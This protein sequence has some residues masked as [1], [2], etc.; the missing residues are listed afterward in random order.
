MAALRQARAKQAPE[1]TEKLSSDELTTLI[2]AVQDLEYFTDHRQ[3]VTAIVEHIL[4]VCNTPGEARDLLF[5]GTGPAVASYLARILPGA[6]WAGLSRE[7]TDRM[8]LARDMLSN[9]IGFLPVSGEEENLIIRAA[10]DVSFFQ[11][12]RQQVMSAVEHL[13]MVC[14][15]QGGARDELMARAPNIA[16]WLDTIVAAEGNFFGVTEQERVRVNLAVEMLLQLSQPVTAQMAAEPGIETP[17]VILPSLPRPM[18]QELGFGEIT[19]N[20]NEK[21]QPLYADLV[22]PESTGYL[23][24]GASIAGQAALYSMLVEGGQEGYG[25]QARQSGHNFLENII[26]NLN[27]VCG[28]SLTANDLISGNWGT[29]AEFVRNRFGVALNGSQDGDVLHALELIDNG[30]FMQA[31]RDSPEGSTVRW[32]LAQILSGALNSIDIRMELFGF[33]ASSEIRLAEYD[34]WVVNVMAVVDMLATQNYRIDSEW[35]QQEGRMRLNIK[36]TNTEFLAGGSA[37]AGVSYYPSGVETPRYVSLAFSGEWTALT[38]EPGGRI[39]AQFRDETGN[40]MGI[41]CDGK[42]YTAFLGTMKFNEQGVREVEIRAGI[43][44]AVPTGGD[45]SFLF[46]LGG[47]ALWDAQD[48]QEFGTKPSYWT[49]DAGVSFQISDIGEP[50]GVEAIVFNLEGGVG[51]GIEPG[52]VGEAWHAGGGIGVVTEWFGINASVAASNVIFL[53]GQQLGGIPTTG[54]AEIVTPTGSLTI[55]VPF[56][57]TDLIQGRE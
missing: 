27:R 48:L 44:Y 47:A 19:F 10:S 42:L 23:E 6:D 24:E 9:S 35:L 51:P 11:N 29:A 28:T 2:R 1:G 38:Q 36:P 56:D 18:R 55:T 5:A 50:G 31:I 14:Q 20:F 32:T 22:D 49:A 13:I 25:A 7:E 4:N 52:A 8:I 12:S 15:Q 37:G 17:Y 53:T 21:F 16:S 3:E 26:S 39:T 30:Q 40:P 45:T 46:T 43:Q 34:T 41:D 57:L 33:N 54:S